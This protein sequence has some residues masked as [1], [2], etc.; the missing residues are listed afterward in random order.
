MKNTKKLVASIMISVLIFNSLVFSASAEDNAKQSVDSGFANVLDFGA[1]IDDKTDDYAAFKAAL[2]TGKNIYVPNGTYYVSES[3]VLENRICRGSTPNNCIINGMNKDNPIFIMQG[4]SQIYDL[5]LMFSKAAGGYTGNEQQGECVAIQAGSKDKPLSYGS[6]VRSMNFSNV[7]TAIYSPAEAGCNGT[8]FDSMDIS[9]Y[10]YR[11]FDMQSENR[12]MNT[13]SNCYINAH[14]SSK[15]KSIANSGFALEGSEYAATLTQINIEHDEIKNPII[16][17]NIKNINISAVHIEGVNVSQENMGFLYL[18]K[19]SGYLAAYTSYFCYVNKM[20][21]S[22]ICFGNSDSKDI[23][24]IGIFHVKGI[25]APDRPTHPDWEEEMEKEGTP[26]SLNGKY[27]SS[28]NHFN[29]KNGAIG[30]YIVKVKSYTYYTYN[31]DDIDRYSAIT[32]SGNLN[33]VYNG[34]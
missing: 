1:T 28:Y 16:L 18:D 11:G 27:S 9:P 4:T 15:I 8:L 22:Q 12:V 3:I 13:Y 34:K 21:T 6:V 31:N 5:R 23:L 25:N 33:L 20:D 30:E 19:T 26:R 29:R 24:N 7:G 2:D 32:K 17:K 10:S 14:V